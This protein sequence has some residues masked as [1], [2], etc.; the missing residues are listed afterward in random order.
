MKDFQV[1]LKEKTDFFETELKKELEE[2]SYPETIAKGMEYA[3][4]NLLYIY[5]TIFFNNF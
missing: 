2:L 4:L 5:F 1:Y 3:I